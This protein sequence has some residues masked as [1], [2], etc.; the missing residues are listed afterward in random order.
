MVTPDNI[1]KLEPNEVFIFGSNLAGNHAGGAA[2]TARELFG[3]IDGVGEGLMGQSYAFPTLD[4][5]MKPLLSEELTHHRDR[6]YLI[7]VQNPEFTF[8]L[9]KIG[10]GIAGFSICKIAPLFRVT[11]SNIIYPKEFIEYN[12]RLC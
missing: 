12:N 4:G 11:L 5:N 6:L 1:T 9:T 10:L 8:Y 2:R 7:A 3:A